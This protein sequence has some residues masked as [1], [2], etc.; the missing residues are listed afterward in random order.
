MPF[1]QCGGLEP[2]SVRVM[3]L[4]GAPPRRPTARS[5]LGAASWARLAASPAR[6]GSPTV[7]LG[8]VPKSFRRVFQRKEG[9]EEPGATPGSSTTSRLRGGAAPTPACPTEGHSLSHTR[10]GTGAPR[11]MVLFP[12]LEGKGGTASASMSS[13]AHAPLAQPETVHLRRPAE[14]RVPHLPDGRSWPLPPQRISGEGKGSLPRGS[15]VTWGTSRAPG[16]HQGP[17]APASTRFRTPSWATSSP[18]SASM[19][20]RPGGPWNLQTTRDH[21]PTL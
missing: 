3:E 2:P 18:A 15:P 13:G 11:I 17:R 19:Q 16:R 1:N 4:H 20:K 5:D 12:L 9:G 21:S 8:K 7:V 10:Y 6:A 14:L